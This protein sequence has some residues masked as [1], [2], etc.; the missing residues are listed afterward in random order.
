MSNELE[1]YYEEYDENGRLQRDNAH[2]VEF[3]TTIHYFDKLFK[4]RSTILDACAGTGAY[5]F[6]LADKGHEVT[7]CDLVEH[8]VNILKNNHNSKNLKEIRVCNVLDLSCFQAQSF[9]VVLCMG[10]LYHLKNDSAMKKAIMEC[11]RVMKPDGLL[12]L[13]Y[14]N[15]FACIAADVDI[16][17]TNIDEALAIY[18]D[19]A[20]LIFTMTTPTKMLELTNDCELDTIHSIG[21]DGLV[22]V[23]SEKLNAAEIENF[24]K[25]IEYHLATCEEASILGSSMHG[26]NICKKRI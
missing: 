26:L 15:K 11:C 16:G 21:T 2:K 18:N 23:L 13:A 20:N 14:L 6:Y 8:N 12:V 4:Q 19:T 3:L 5:S 22:Y 24:N 17:L 1:K 10:A 7:A 25:W 9:D